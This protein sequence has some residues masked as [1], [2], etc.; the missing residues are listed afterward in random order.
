MKNYL[1][2]F[3]A[4]ASIILIGIAA[5]SCG[6]SRDQAATTEQINNAKGGTHVKIAGTNVYI[7]PP[8][9]FLM[10]AT[11]EGMFDPSSAARI[12]VTQRER[13]FD[14]V[15]NK[16]DP[17]DNIIDQ[18]RLSINQYEGYYK[19]VGQEKSFLRDVLAFGNDN[20][21]VTLV[22]EIPTKDSVVI[23]KVRTAMRTVVLLDEKL[24]DPSDDAIFK[25]DVKKTSLKFARLINR[26]LIY[27]ESGD[28][29]SSS[30]F[31]FIVAFNP[32]MSGT[33]DRH[34]A[35]SQKYAREELYY[36]N[37][38]IKESKPIT[39]EEMSGYEITAEG[40]NSRSNAYEVLYLVTLFT[41][42]GAYTM[43]GS[44][45]ERFDDN[46]TMFKQV[47]RTFH[48]KEN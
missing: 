21:T 2:A 36:K 8:E 43:L 17:T 11:A 34:E 6:G 44:A 18:H 1:T 5:L 27:T 30:R 35:I 13:P 41:K 47:A 14:G 31:G 28:M 32:A 42:D 12:T 3:E 37:L 38:E 29:I 16:P 20:V 22:A 23:N 39:I 33:P 9:G 24:P 25:V 26:M 10:T 7:I 40:T 4:S 45:S 19:T 15:L 46:L 48:L